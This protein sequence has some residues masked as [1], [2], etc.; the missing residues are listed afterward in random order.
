MTYRNKALRDTARN[1]SCIL[2]GSDNGT[3]ESAHYFGRMRHRLGGGMSHKVTDAATAALCSRCH[4]EF[5]SY[6]AGNTAERS[7]EFLLAIVLTWD[8]LCKL[9][10]VVIK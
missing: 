6:A 3:V 5:D 9:G 7:E 10:K 4:Q 2:C 1:M 8:R